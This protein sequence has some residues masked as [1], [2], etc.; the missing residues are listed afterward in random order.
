MIRSVAVNF[1][2]KSMLNLFT[3]SATDMA[4][5]RAARMRSLR[6]NSESSSTE[7]T[8]SEGDTFFTSST[9]EPFNDN[10]RMQ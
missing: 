4:A 3:N 10:D 5:Y 2:R 6:S 8:G 7:R 1:P 9:E